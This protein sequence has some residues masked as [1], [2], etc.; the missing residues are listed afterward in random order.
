MS[1][2]VDNLL[3]MTRL[4]SGGVVPNQQWHVLEEIVGTA[5][6]RLPRELQKHP[7]R[8]AIPSDLP[9][10]SLDGVLME[11]VFVNLLENAARYTPAGTQIEIGARLQADSVE[12]RVADSG[13][14][15]PP[16]SERRLFEKF[17]RGSVS[18]ADGRRGVGLGLSICQAIVQS[19]GGQISARNRPGGGAEFLISLPNAG[20]APKIALDEAVANTGS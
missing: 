18:S 12:I 2:L 11:Q 14:G 1:R 17:F 3:D 19:H 4:Q 6:G 13:P 7:V 5:L 15:V 10:L 8:V 16:G 9:L 20:D